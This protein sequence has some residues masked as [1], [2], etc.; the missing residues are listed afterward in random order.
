MA[1]PVAK[2]RVA[3][4]ILSTSS[5]SQ[6]PATAAA[7]PKP[8]PP[9]ATQ[10]AASDARAPSGARADY[11][12]EEAERQ[13]HPDVYWY[14]SFRCNLACRHCSVFSS[15]D[16]DTSDDLTTEGAMLVIEQ[17]V[18]LGVGTALV[19]GGEALYRPDAMDILRAATGSGVKVGLETNGLII[20]D[21]FIEFARDAQAR[22]MFGVA[23]SLDGGTPETHDRVRGHGTFK[24]TLHNLHRLKEGGVKFSIQCI[25]NNDN[26]ASI[27]QYIELSKAL[28]P[29]L[30]DTQLGILNA[31]GRGDEFIQEVGLAAEDI[32]RIFALIEREKKDFSG[33][34]V[35][36]VPPAVVPPRFLGFMYRTENV[37]GC[38]TCQFPLLGV[39][40]NGDVTICA[41][42]RDNEQ[43][44]FGNV[45]THRLKD[46]WVQTRMDALRTHYVAADHLAGICGDCVFQKSCKGSCRAWA[47]EQGGSFDSPF[48]ICASLERA[49]QFPRAYR[50]SE[51]QKALNGAPATG[52]LAKNTAC[53]H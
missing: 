42:S 23:V 9:L 31:V 22:K 4:P 7:P 37:S 41:V 44:C 34:I 26:Y 50:L 48:P 36:K 27:P 30:V 32:P 46:I 19:S 53:S 25:L 11:E 5:P 29:E 40:P 3:L 18:E 24:R 1:D 28:M 14:L 6:A 39:L 15:P 16:V 33:S 45:R 47:Y 52:L 2:G 17:M 49:G 35:V 10:A 20:T 51:Q 21:E 12:R 8:R 43:V 13:F 38:T